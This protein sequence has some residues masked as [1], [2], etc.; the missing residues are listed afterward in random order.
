MLCSLK[1]LYKWFHPNLSWLI[2]KHSKWEISSQFKCYSLNTIPFSL[3]FW[4]N[5]VSSLIKLTNVDL[6]FKW[7]FRS[8]HKTICILKCFCFKYFFSTNLAGQTNIFTLPIVGQWRWFF[9][10][11]CAEA[12]NLHMLKL[13][14]SVVSNLYNCSCCCCFQ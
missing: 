5:A 1:D 13:I 6:N 4:M 9:F 11:V 12:K 10:F 2:D 7:Y 14:Q 3:D 8:V